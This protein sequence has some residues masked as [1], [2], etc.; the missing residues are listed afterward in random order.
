MSDFYGQRRSK[1][2]WFSV[3]YRYRRRCE[4]S[5]WEAFNLRAGYFGSRYRRANRTTSDWSKWSST[6]G[7]E[8]RKGNRYFLI[9]SDFN[10]IDRVIKIYE[11]S[12]KRII[13]SF[14]VSVMEYVRVLH[15]Q[16]LRVFPFFQAT[17]YSLV[18]YFYFLDR[19]V[20]LYLRTARSS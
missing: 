1:Y 8:N 13:S 19:L 2:Q 5:R 15:S 7:S 3:F 10:F 12:K 9:I 14:L 6:D 11:K 4:F 20:F 18:Q 16:F 17:H